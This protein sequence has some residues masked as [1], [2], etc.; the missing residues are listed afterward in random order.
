RLRAIVADASRLHGRVRIGLTGM[1][2][3]END[4]MQSS[5]KDMMRASVL[6]LFGVAALFMAGFGG[7]RYP[8]LCVL[9]LLVGMAWSFAYVTLAVGHLNILSVSF[10]VILIG[11]G[12][13]FGI[14]F[15][16]GYLQRRPDATDSRDA[17]IDTA[18]GVG[19]G[20]ITGGVTTAIAFFT[21]ALTQFTGVAELGVIAGGGILLCVLAAVVVLPSM[22]QWMDQ[23]RE[24]SRLP[25]ILPLGDLFQPLQRHPVLS[26]IIGMA[27]VVFLA[28]GIFWLEF[29]HNLLNLQSPRLESVRLEHELIE[30]ADQSVWFALSMARDVEEVQ[31]RKAAFAKLPT[32]DRVEEVASLAAA[33]D[34]AETA[35]IERISK[36]LALVPVESPAVAE[37]SAVRLRAV[38]EELRERLNRV[39]GQLNQ[40]ARDGAALSGAEPTESTSSEM[41]G[42]RTAGEAADALVARLHSMPDE[43]VELRIGEFQQRAANELLDRL[44][45][46]RAA[47]NPEPPA[48]ADLPESIAHRFV[49]KRGTHLLRIYAAG[50]VWDMDRL[51]EF[52]RDIESVD[53]RV[54]GHPVQTFYASRQMQRSYV[55][56]AIYALLAVAITLMLDFRSI[57]SSLLAMIPVG[58]GM[59]QLFGLLGIMG[60]PLNPANLIVLPLIL[61]IGIDDG[62]HVVHE[63][64][65]QK[66]RYRLGN[67]TATAIVITSATTMIG[68]GCMMFAEHRGIRSLG[69]VLTL[70]VFCCLV[71]SLVVLPAILRLITARREEVGN[72]ESSELKSQVDDENCPR[73][74]ESSNPPERI[75]PRRVSR[76]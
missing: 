70:G 66:G 74:E 35:A 22:M 45:Q 17:L 50:N 75:Q 26:L 63:F 33:S 59:I 43:Q 19:P 53:P 25:T 7:W 48:L 55:H 60:M 42:L 29:D 41:K 21:A 46:L 14:H 9:T 34:P 13:D 12:I 65:N 28:G 36:R 4:E 27:P 47:A 30:R 56:A 52:V 6:S 39:V 72:A 31:R 64:R 67:A 37:P 18:G 5:Q 24:A 1:P 54:T 40:A 61:G 38:A 32:V 11:L 44:R 76:S 71:T 3:L 23:G 62:V 8:A 16:A 57:R 2:V 73:V 69:Q 58:L 68:F 49:G 15:V 51:T 10:G 20:I